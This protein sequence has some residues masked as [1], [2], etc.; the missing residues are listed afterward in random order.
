M[1]AI[2]ARNARMKKRNSTHE[3]IEVN[4]GN[5]KAIK[6][7]KSNTNPAPLEI[8]DDGNAE[9]EAEIIPSIPSIIIRNNDRNPDRQV[10][11]L[12]YERDE[13]WQ[14]PNIAYFCSSGTSNTGCGWLCGTFFPT[15]GITTKIK[16]GEKTV[17]I[18]DECKGTGGH[19]L[20]MSDITNGATSNGII[21]SIDSFYTELTVVLNTYF[22]SIRGPMHIPPPTLLNL[23]DVFNT[24]FLTEQQLLL[25]YRLSFTHSEEGLHHIGL[26]GW[27]C[28]TFKLSDFCNARWGNPTPINIPISINILN[29]T[30]ACEFIKHYNASVNFEEMHSRIV[31]HNM[32]NG[33]Q[34][35]SSAIN[36]VI[37][38]NSFFYRP[39]IIKAKGIQKRN[40]IT[41]KRK[42]KGYKRVKTIRKYGKN[43]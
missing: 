28:E 40:K 11:I 16:D 18:D 39:P 4:S 35:R 5:K 23:F 38:L 15:G 7:N 37:Q 9:A 6:A 21:R 26:W 22:A 30:D 41:N 3:N 17:G 25:S 24:Y 2:D 36:T 29:N 19:L 33:R 12:P 1:S 32:A 42:R 43:M 13:L 31:A 8:I 14:N 10:I 34:F 20:K 27:E